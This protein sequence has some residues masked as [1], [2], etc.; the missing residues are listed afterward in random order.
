MKEMLLLCEKPGPITPQFLSDLLLYLGVSYAGAME[1]RNDSPE[2]LLADREHFLQVFPPILQARVAKRSADQLF[3]EDLKDRGLIISRL[4]V[5]P[6]FRLECQGW[7]TALMGI[8]LLA[9]GETR[10]NGAE[11]ETVVPSLAGAVARL[12]AACGL[13]HGAKPKPRKTPHRA[14]HPWQPQQGRQ[15]ALK[16]P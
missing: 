4:Q 10:L 5:G 15:I 16:I 13:S 6:S 8:A 3:R 11:I 14:L 2:T 1:L 9:G 12:S 7:G